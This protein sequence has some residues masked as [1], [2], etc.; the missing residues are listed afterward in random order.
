MSDLARAG[1]LKIK[2]CYKIENKRYIPEVSIRTL[3]EQ[4]F[5]DLG[6]S[7]KRLENKRKWKQKKQKESN[8]NKR[9]EIY[10]KL[11]EQHPK[12]RGPQL[13]KKALRNLLE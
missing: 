9:L 4:F 3:T 7:K 12:L 8:D 13:A 6:F 1:Y 10:H 5:F 11:K 2:T